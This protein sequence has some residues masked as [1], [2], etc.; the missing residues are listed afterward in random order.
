MKDMKKLNALLQNN[1]IIL[2]DIG[3]AGGINNRFAPVI[4]NLKSIL[5]EPDKD[6]NELLKNE[7]HQIVYNFACG[8]KEEEKPLFLNK[9]RTTSS[10]F[11][12]NK[13]FIA[14]FPYADRYNSE[15][16]I[17][18]QIKKLDF[19]TRDFPY[20]DFLK[21]DTQGSE[22]GIINGA[23]KVLENCWGVEVE[24]EFQPMYEGQ[25]LFC[26][27]DYALKKNKFELFDIQRYY[28]ARNTLPDITK[29]RGQIIFG[30][31]LYFKPIEEIVSIITKIGDDN[32]RRS[33]LF[34]LI[35][36]L[37]IYQRQD[38]ALEILTHFNKDLNKEEKTLIKN[39]CNQKVRTVIPNFKGKGKLLK[40]FQM[41]AGFF[42]PKFWYKSDIE[43]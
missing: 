5:F 28:W 7:D 24:I 35:A 16:E 43:L 26:H 25:P 4:N 2:V 39:V 30:N 21:I 12:P 32:L 27:I 6:S 42:D 41:I 8:E 31:A 33:R 1:R 37:V 34:S 38:Y 36:I 13:K 23:T 17:I 19:I 11:R 15:A 29:T 3:A 14:K 10:F 22:L 9:Q 18:M 40:L 20:I